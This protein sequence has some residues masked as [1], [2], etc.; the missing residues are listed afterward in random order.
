MQV[1]K[2]DQLALHLFTRYVIA[3]LTAQLPIPFWMPLI[4]QLSH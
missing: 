3:V 4:W 2:K 1:G